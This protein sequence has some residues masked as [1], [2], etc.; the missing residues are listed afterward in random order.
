MKKYDN[1]KVQVSLAGE[2]AVLSQLALHG[3]DANMVL[4]NTKSVDI[5][6]SDPETSRL[7]KLEVKTSY[8][9]NK[10]IIKSRLFGNFLCSWMLSEKNEKY[11][12][13]IDAN[14]FYCFVDINKK[15]EQFKFYIIP[16]KVVADYVTK[17]DRY[18]FREKKKE[19]KSVKKT[20]I[21]NFR[22]GTIKE[23]SSYKIKTPFAE[24]YK[25][26]WNFEIK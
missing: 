15:T 22:I 24:D 2:F 12:K 20:P 11:N 16:A 21:R 26:N 3:K 4:G 17:E 19:G 6:V 8:N 5:L 7:L 1:N 13:K 10:K 9:N 23:K 14:L 25:D 18:F